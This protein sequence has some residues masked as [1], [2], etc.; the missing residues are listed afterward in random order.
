MVG[1]VISHDGVEA[2]V[3]GSLFQGGTTLFVEKLF[4]CVTDRAK[5]FLIFDLNVSL[6]ILGLLNLTPLVG[7]V[8]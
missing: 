8:K 5:L 1:S 2:T 7:P 6:R 4:F 3:S